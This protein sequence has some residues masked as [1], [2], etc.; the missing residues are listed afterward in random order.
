M[1]CCSVAHSSSLSGSGGFYLMLY[2]IIIISAICTWLRP[3]P[4]ILS[5]SSDWNISLNFRIYS[6]NT[7][8]I[9]FP[10]DA[11]NPE[12][13]TNPTAINPGLYF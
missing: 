12:A 1:C 3:P 6:G 9:L 13:L 11:G 7:Q 2:D 5:A 10:W 4:K 8:L